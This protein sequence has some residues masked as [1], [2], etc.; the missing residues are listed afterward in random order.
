MLHLMGTISLWI[1]TH[2]YFLQ[3][4][5]DLKSKTVTNHHLY[6]KQQLKH[7][8]NQIAELNVARGY[9][10]GL[11]PCQWNAALPRRSEGSAASGLQSSEPAAELGPCG[12]APPDP[13]CATETRPIW[14]RHT[15]RSNVSDSLQQTACTAWLNPPLIWSYCK[16]SICAFSAVTL[17]LRLLATP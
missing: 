15:G 7:G 4:E 17:K 11:T 5:E 14:D 16:V 12:S 3:Q 13:H 2:Q 9:A 8:W 10:A 6:L 1:C